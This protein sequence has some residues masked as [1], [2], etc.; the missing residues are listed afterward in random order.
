MAKVKATKAKA[1]QTS[2][3]KARGGSLVIVESPAKAKTINRYLGAGFRVMASLGHIKDLPKS[4]LGVDVEHDFRP[5]YQP[6]PSKSKVIQELR[7]GAM[8]ADAIY[9][10]ADPDREGEAICQHLAEE[11]GNGKLVHRV[12]FNEITKNAIQEAFEH[13]G[14]VNEKLVEAQ[15]TRRILDRL[16]GYKISPLLWDKVRRGLSAGRVQTVALRLIVEREREIRAFEREEYWTVAA[17][18]NARVPPSFDARLVRVEGREAILRG[19]GGF[20]SIEDQAAR[21]KFRIGTEAAAKALHSRLEAQSFAVAST[22]TR[23]EQRNPAPPFITSTLQQ[24]AA[25][26][27]HLS[28][29]RSMGLAQRLY[30]GVECG[31]EGLVGLITYMRTDST[32]VA[33]VAL[34]EVRELIAKSYGERYVP[35][36][37]NIYR[38]KKGAQDAHEAI[39]PTSSLRTPDRMAKFLNEDELKLYRLVWQRFVASQMEP[40]RFDRTT[41]EITAGE[42]DLRATGLVQKFDGFLKVYQEGRDQVEEDDDQQEGRLPAVEAGEALRLV[43]IKPVQHFTEPP[44]RFNEAS[45]VK[46]LE[47]RGIGRPSTYAAILSVI[48]QREYVEKQKGRFVPSELGM[49]VTELLVKNFEDIFDIAYT[50]RLE[51]ALDGIED[52]SRAW[53]ETLEDFYEK[54]DKDL[55]LAAKNM[56]DIKRMEEPT[57]FSCEKCGKPMVIKWG[58]HGKFL[59]CTGYPECTNTRDLAKDPADPTATETPV[60]EREEICENCGRTMVLKRGRFGQFLACSGYPDCKTT[61]KIGQAEKKPPVPTDEPCPKCGNPLVIR[62]GRYGEF[63]SC[64]TYPKC[65]YIKQNS[66]GV[67][68]PECKKGQ[69]VEKRSRRGTFYSCD[70]YPKCKYSLRNKPL[71]QKCP[72]CGSA[73]LLEKSSKTGATVECP[74]ES[75]DYNQAA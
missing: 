55:K 8:K 22:A 29:K 10:A 6:I 1:K 46:E 64:G 56:A 32:R 24:E 68:C 38:S 11:L 40:A 58:K 30:E 72:Q 63:T 69:M 7:L 3:T 42:F 59:A 50:A 15:Q 65:K 61:R 16:V 51:D 35:G 18:L 21:G 36:S 34:S 5:T 19:E 20:K 44:P 25:R 66:T 54:F 75:C 26:K 73:Y 47:K 71:A 4:N 17:H 43:E 57:E 48:Q 28:V 70:R 67:E 23:D 52:G 39:R 62:E 33:D 60:P 14:T 27:L 37:P 2:A 41:I 45:L 31:E 49:I 12:L 9:L 53:V 74:S 13:P